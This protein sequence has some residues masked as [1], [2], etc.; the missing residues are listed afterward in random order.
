MTEVKDINMKLTNIARKIL[1]EADAPI[2]LEQLKK[3]NNSNMTWKIQLASTGK[4]FYFPGGENA[5]F[6][7]QLGKY[8]HEIPSG[9]S[10]DLLAWEI[11]EAAKAFAED[12]DDNIANDFYSAMD[13]LLSPSGFKSSIKSITPSVGPNDPL[14]LAL[15]RGSD[16]IIYLTNYPN[17]GN[18]SE[19]TDV[20]W[21]K[22]YDAKAI[23]DAS[24]YIG[25]KNEN[26]FNTNFKISQRTQQKKISTPGHMDQV[27][28]RVIV[29]ANPK[30][31]TF[32]GNLANL[33]G[34]GAGGFNAA[35]FAN[36]LWWSR[37]IR[38]KSDYKAVDEIIKKVA[39]KYKNQESGPTDFFFIRKGNVYLKQW[40]A[41]ESSLKSARAAANRGKFLDPNV[42]VMALPG[43]VPLS[44]EYNILKSIAPDMVSTDSDGSGDMKKAIRWAIITDS[45]I[46][47]EAVTKNGIL[48]FI[49][50]TNPPDFNEQVGEFPND[51]TPTST[52][53]DEIL[54][55]LLENDI[56]TYNRDTNQ[57]ILPFSNN[58]VKFHQDLDKLQTWPSK[59]LGEVPD[60]NETS[61]EEGSEEEGSEE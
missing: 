43:R 48:N 3:Y 33:V 8:D 31:A 52:E 51:T 14:D 45:M 10:I 11:L 5:K 53:R 57:I 15:L 21:A 1:Q 28:A 26:W 34:L 46:N 38:S 60:P 32:P 22:N 19:W 2:S 7:I 50:Q 30:T 6:Q 54:L 16:K 49:Y 41:A 23:W 44:A 61:E 39:E 40:D 25:D 20:K 36:I 29:S 37:G 9:G 12:V 56:A 58:V 59:P 27:A 4:T 17:A 47:T 13:Y 18:R 42:K 55:A 24:V 35:K